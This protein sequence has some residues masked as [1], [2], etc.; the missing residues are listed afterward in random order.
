MLDDDV[1]YVAATVEVVTCLSVKRDKFSVE[2][3]SVDKVIRRF[4][5]SY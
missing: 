1:N 5:I 4:N 2:V 3:H